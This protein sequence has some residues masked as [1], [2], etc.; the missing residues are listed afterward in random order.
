MAGNLD[1]RLNLVRDTGKFPPVLVER[2]GRWIER[3][4]ERELYRINPLSWATSQQTDENLVVDLF[5]HATAAG[6]FD[7]IWSVLCTQC[8]MNITTPGGLR[9]FSKTQRHC[10]L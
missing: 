9:A 6:V 7:L 1:S 2:L 8:G 3:A 10:R 5:L 4:E